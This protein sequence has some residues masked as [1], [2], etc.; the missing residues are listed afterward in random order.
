MAMDLFRVGIERVF[1]GISRE[2]EARLTD[3][4]RTMRDILKKVELGNE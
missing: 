4:L 3:A 1:A 2:D